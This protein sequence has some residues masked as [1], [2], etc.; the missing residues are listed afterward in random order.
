MQYNN[1]CLLSSQLGHKMKMEMNKVYCVGQHLDTFSLY[2]NQ[3]NYIRRI[4]SQYTFISFIQCWR[5]RSNLPY[6]CFNLSFIEK[7]NALS[8]FQFIVP[9]KNLSC[10]LFP[11]TEYVSSTCQKAEVL[12]DVCDFPFLLWVAKPTPVCCDT[13]SASFKR[14]SCHRHPLSLFT[15][16][17]LKFPV[18]HPQCWYKG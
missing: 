5:N 7:E 14:S 18:I 2:Q 13:Q 1:N 12:S 4:I 15:Q 17:T 11:C 9:R 8:H 3:R 6:K 10:F 16:P